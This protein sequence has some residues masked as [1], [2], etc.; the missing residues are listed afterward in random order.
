MLLW[1]VT[2][3]CEPALLVKILMGRTPHCAKSLPELEFKYVNYPNHLC[4]GAIV[5]RWRLLLLET[6]TI[7][8]GEITL[9][10][11]A[12]FRGTTALLLETSVI[13]T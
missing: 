6:R 8:R 4:F 12:R 1:G 5:W 3:P 10:D 13:S 2:L 11:A 9:A 7:S